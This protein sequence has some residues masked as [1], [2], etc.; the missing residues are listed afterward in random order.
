MSLFV[1]L[2]FPQ[3]HYRVYNG[4]HDLREQAEIPFLRRI[5]REVLSCSGELPPFATLSSDKEDLCCVTRLFVNGPSTREIDLMS[6][7]VDG[8]LCVWFSDKD[9]GFSCKLYIID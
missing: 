1:R 3:L 9:F 5:P 4:S 6:I 2:R 7:N 8:E